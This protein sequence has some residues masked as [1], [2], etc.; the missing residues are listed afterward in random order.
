MTEETV[1]APAPEATP[2][3]A[4]TTTEAPAKP[5][6]PE[7]TPRGAIDRAFDTIEAAEA[8][9]GAFNGVDKVLA[10]GE[11]EP[12]KQDRD[13]S[14]RFKAKDGAE[15]TEEP[16][17]AEKQEKAAKT[18]EKPVEKAEK[19]PKEAKA[20]EKEAAKIEDQPKETPS[21][22]TEAPPRFSPDAK[23][24][25]ANAPEPVKAEIH[26]AV[27]EMETGLAAYQQELEPLRE[28]SEMAKQYGTSIKQAL[29]NYVGLEKQLH[30]DPM[31]GLKSV[32]DYVG[33]NPTDFAAH[34]LG[35]EADPNKSANEAENRQLRQEIAALK[36]QVTGIVDNTQSQNQQQILQQ[37]QAFQNETNPQTGE[38]LRP[39]FEELASDIGLLVQTGRAN[40]LQ[41]AYEM[42]ERLNP[43]PVIPTP[44]APAP[45]VPKPD[46]AAQTRKGSLSVTGA[47]GSGSNP[48]TKKPPSSVK[49]SLDSAFANLGL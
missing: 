5:K 26:R 30:A 6:E 46:P 44:P 29:D 38:L 48:V 40:D 41:E 20:E 14:G 1:A 9:P 21:K 31:A 19:E 23:A 17:K 15:V 3:P 27:K 47:P 2:A 37:I 28:Y 49:E 8:D 22:F 35:Q 39:R 18:D 24:E 43:A 45:L 32:F 42:A 25:W 10:N 11:A 13:E 7:V 4:E 33:I 12:E 34:I 36:Q 16:A